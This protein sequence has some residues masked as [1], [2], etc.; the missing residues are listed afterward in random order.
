[1]SFGQ[2]LGRLREAAG[3]SRAELARRARVP[4]S[5]LRNWEADRGFPALPAALRLAAALGVPV[6]SFAAGVEDLA[7][8]DPATPPDRPRRRQKGKTHRRR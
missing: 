4:V 2:H 8:A 1:M 5:T 7:E 3:L 6:E